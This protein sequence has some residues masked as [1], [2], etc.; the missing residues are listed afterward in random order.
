MD[1][2]QG[3]IL[4]PLDIYRKNMDNRPIRTDLE[5]WLAFLSFTDPDRIGG[6]LERY[7]MFRDMYQQI[8]DLCLDTG[9]VMNMYSKELAMM[10][11]NTVLYMM[12]QRDQVI[13]QQAKELAQNE[14]TIA[15]KDLALEQKDLA[16]A[17]N[18]QMIAQKDLAL[19]QNEQTIAQM[20]L[21]LEQA[22]KEIAAL[23]AL[24]AAPDR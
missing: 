3:Y 7:P 14:Q 15:Q 11:R 22:Q 6:L 23:K 18:E 19:A 16:L 4:I 12:D 9:K 10:D 2:L 21:A 5:A 17:L 24:L 13:A 1:T 8:Y 20:D